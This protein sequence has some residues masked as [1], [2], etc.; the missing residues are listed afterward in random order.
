MRHGD[1][2]AQALEW[3]YGVLSTDQELADLL[4]VPLTGLPDRVWA[5]T[6]PSGTPAPWVV[7]SASQGLDRLGLGTVP[8]LG[9]VVPLNVRSVWQ[10]RDPGAGA[11]VAR[12]LYAL[13]HGATN[14]PLADGGTILTV[15]RTTSLDYPEDAGGIQYRHTG[16]LYQ[17]EVN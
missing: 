5:E 7:V 17:V 14:V 13:L 9:S 8:R 1:E 12:R 16:G 11:A 2:Q 10:T 15:R 3:A 6:A 4:G